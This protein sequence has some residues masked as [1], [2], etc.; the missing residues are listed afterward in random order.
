MKTKKNRNVEKHKKMMLYARMLLGT[1]S[2]ES[3]HYF[4]SDGI[5]KTTENIKQYRKDQKLY[6]TST[7]CYNS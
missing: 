5:V 4:I 6:P 1:S 3:A 7:I 2:Y